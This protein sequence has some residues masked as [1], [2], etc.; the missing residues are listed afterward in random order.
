M[1]KFFTTICLA[2]VCS[3]AFAQLAVPYNETFESFTPFT[4]PGNGWVTTTPVGFQVYS[5]HGTNSSKGLIKNLNNFT[6]KDSVTSPSIGKVA[7]NSYLKFD[8]RIVDFSL[9]PSFGTIIASGDQIRVAVSANG[10]P[11]VDVIT[12]DQTNHITASSFVKDSVSLSQFANDSI[13]IR[14]AVKRASA[15]D[16]FVDFDN[17]EVTGTSIPSS[18][19]ENTLANGFSVYPNPAVNSFTLN[20][21]N[22]VGAKNVSIY[23]MAGQ[24]VY[25]QPIEPSNGKITVSTQNIPSG[26]YLIQALI[27]GRFENKKLI[28]K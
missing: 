17:I 21:G 28:I 20:F 3:T 19:N 9:Y 16:Y 22:N 15:G 13:K 14:F 7:A 6:T 24:L 2:I 12:I 5:T 26:L 8:Y 23:N 25:S 10:G 1:N 11:F 27:N 18:I 4:Q